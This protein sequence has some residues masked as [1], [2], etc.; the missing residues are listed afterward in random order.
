[1]DISPA[2][3]SGELLPAAGGRQDGK[4][5]SVL[6]K[7]G[8]VREAVV[9]RWLEGQIQTPWR[10]P[11]PKTLEKSHR[12]PWQSF[13]CPNLQEK[14]ACGFGAGRDSVALT[15][16]D[17]GVS[18][19]SGELHLGWASVGVGVRAEGRSR[20]GR[21]VPSFLQSKKRRLD[22]ESTVLSTGAQR[23]LRTR[24]RPRVRPPGAQPGGGGHSD[25]LKNSW[26]LRQGIPGV[27]L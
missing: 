22:A 9:T 19:P 25:Q 18:V 4:E 16:A 3:M 8:D 11:F 13:P 17:L 6:V 12:C 24:R 23:R 21:N 2:D 10:S 15:G 20:R 27:N 1:M 26:G 5:D 7:S 14:Q